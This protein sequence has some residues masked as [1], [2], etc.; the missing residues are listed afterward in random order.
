[1]DE[2]KKKH[3]GG[4]PRVYDVGELV[5]KL[6][7]FIDETEDP[8]IEKFCVDRTMPRVQTLLEMS[9]RENDTDARE[10]ASAIKRAYDKQRIYLCSNGSKEMV[11]D[12]FRLKQP[13]HGYKDKLEIQQNITVD[14][15]SAIT[16]ARLRAKALLVDGE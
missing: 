6:N 16:A 7:D 14:T 9:K 2:V 5:D 4:R 1:M 8:M 3:A 11:K 15:A 13:Q 12:I 10:L